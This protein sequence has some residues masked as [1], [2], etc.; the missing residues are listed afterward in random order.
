MEKALLVS[1]RFHEGRY[2]GTGDWPPAPA[3]LFQAL[4]AGSA[5]GAIVPAATRD[6]LDWLEKMQPPIVAAPRGV[7]GQSFVAWVPNNDLDAELSKRDAQNL[8]NAVAAIRVGKPI[9][10]ILFDAETPFLYCWSIDDDR[11]AAVLC[12]MA[13]GLY[14]LG[15]GV[16]MAWA[17]AIVATVAE[18][19][20]R[21]SG[22]DGIVYRPTGGVGAGCD[23]LCPQ[24]GLRRNLATRFEGMRNRFRTGGTNRK[25]VQVFV[26]PV[27]PQPV[28]VAYNVRPHRLVFELRES[29]AQGAFAVRRLRAASE[30][31]RE[32]R[33]RAEARLSDAEP[34]LRERLERYLI[35][36]GATDSDKAMR[37]LIVPIPSV[38]HPHADMGV[39]RIA[40]YVPQSC[41]LKADDLAWAF[42]QVAWTDDDGVIVKELRRIGDDRMVGRFERR[43][44]RWRSVTPLALPMARRRRI[45]PTRMAEEAKGV[46]ER[47]K[48]EAHAAAAVRQVLR[49]AGVQSP[50]ADIRVQREPFDRLGARAESFA[51]GTRFAKETLW[52][53]EVSFAEPVEGP[54]LLGDGRYLGLGLMLPD[55]K[56]PEMLAFVIK[57]GLEPGAEPVEVARAARR[58][59]MARVQR[60]LSRGAKIPTWAGRF[61]TPAR[62]LQ[63]SLSRGAKI[64]TYVSGHGKDGEPAGDGVHRHIAVVADL[65]RRRILYVAPTRLWRGVR[66]REIE[67][68]HRLTVH[69]LEG[70]DVLRA[71]MAGKL[72]LAPA[73][74]NEEEDPLL[75]P[76]RVWESVTDYAVTRHYRRLGAEDALRADVIAEL[77]RCGLPLPPQDAI[78]VLTVRRGRR[79]GLSGRLRIAFAVARRGPLI[80]G[81]SA[82]KGGGLFVG[83]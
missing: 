76:A 21:F 72:R 71:G 75:A 25:P 10:P 57:A 70:M 9:H 30:L 6:A 22:Y 51:G 67:D 17:E 41:P 7:P 58:A 52:H 63:R 69:A 28:S 26:Q 14:Q 2:H 34:A 62:P 82:H 19:E 24:P 12:E 5:R 64:P 56:A 74:L 43:G 79:G 49:H 48:E 80:L 54:L 4:L 73:A 32:I 3:R 55:E 13:G 39:R 46:R 40:V 83:R 78:T 23:M 50:A 1:V 60:S 37:V 68:D 36:R 47:A 16:D 20:D 59:M 44:R 27:K 81:R 18:A 35:G 11:Q 77:Q 29:D 38:G 53:A 8:D 45:E 66:R 31:V 33:D 42:A 65:S 61:S 15:R